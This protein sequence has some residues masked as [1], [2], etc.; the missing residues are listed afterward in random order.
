MVHPEPGTVDSGQRLGGLD[1]RG[2]EKLPRLRGSIE[3]DLQVYP[4]RRIDMRKITLLVA[5]GLI[6]VTLQPLTAQQQGY[7]RPRDGRGPGDR[8]AVPRLEAL[9]EELDLSEEQSAKWTATIDEHFKTREAT[10]KQMEDL[11]TEFNRLAETENPD[12][13]RLGEIALTLH[14]EARDNR[15]ERQRL[16][17]ELKGILTP[18]Q[19]EHF[20]SL[21]ASRQFGRSRE[22]PTRRDQP[23]GEPDR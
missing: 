11:R 22:R 7:G 16:V 8:S 4:S 10:R 17:A 18:E 19:Q 20:D 14:R 12:L 5:A 23:T 3:L 13:E 15:P 1:W 21:V 6:L 9:A 2:H